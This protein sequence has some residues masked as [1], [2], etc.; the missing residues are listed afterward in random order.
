MLIAL[1]ATLAL[2]VLRDAIRTTINLSEKT[3]PI[4]SSVLR[5]GRRVARI[6]PRRLTRTAGLAMT[7]AVVVSWTL[8]LWAAWTIALLDPAVGVVVTG[9]DTPL[10]LL[11]TLYVAGFSIF[12]LGT[13]D[14]S[15]TN[16]LGRLVTVVASGTGL[17]TVTLEVTYL[18]SLTSAAAHERSTAR[19]TYALG[20]DA[21]QIVSRAYDGTTFRQAEP[22]LQQLA[23]DLS[24]LA[25]QHRTFPV[26]HD[27]LPSRRELA[28]GPSLLALSDALDV[29]HLAAPVECAVNRLTYQ[30]VTEAIDGVLA[31]LPPGPQLSDP[32]PAPDADTL[33]RQAGCEQ[34][35]ELLVDE[36]IATRRR[37]VYGLAAEEGWRSAADEALRV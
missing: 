3:G 30:Q 31:G 13:G 24:T 17:F 1:G 35:R 28:L 14:L 27:V 21:A 16:T 34:R 11:D 29:M 5:L 33:L 10:G 8:G 12:T 19:Q 23:R 2:F 15:T 7:I 20:H 22:L 26:L 36:A 6:L 4:A 9:Q 37:G 32:P 25:E 18:L